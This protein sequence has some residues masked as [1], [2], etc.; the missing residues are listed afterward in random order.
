LDRIN[1][2]GRGETSSINVERNSIRVSDACV[3]GDDGS[4]SS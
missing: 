1:K 3:R 4:P 2:R